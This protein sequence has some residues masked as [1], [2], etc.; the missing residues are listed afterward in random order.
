M[1]HVLDVSGVYQ[2]RDTM[3]FP[4]DEALEN[5]TLWPIFAHVPHKCSRKVIWAM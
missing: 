4:K 3:W 2:V 5:S 1:Y